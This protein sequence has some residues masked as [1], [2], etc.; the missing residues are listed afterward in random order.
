MSQWSD[1]L[2]A[3]RYHHYD[4]FTL[5]LFKIVLRTISYK[6][7]PAKYSILALVA[8]YIDEIRPNISDPIWLYRIFKAD[9]GVDIVHFLT[10]VHYRFLIFK[11]NLLARNAM[12][13]ML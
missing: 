4:T 10:E 13:R 9:P 8:V 1:W 12:Q 7:F 2:I 3:D 6:V 5:D 11:R